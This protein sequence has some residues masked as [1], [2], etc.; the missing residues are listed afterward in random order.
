M[1]S[2]GGLALGKTGLAICRDLRSPYWFGH[3]VDQGT[4]PFLI[5]AQ[6]PAVR[7]SHGEALLR[8]RAIEN[9]MFVS[10]CHR[11]GKTRDE[12]FA[13]G[14]NLIS[15]E[16]VGMLAGRSDQTV[17]TVQVDLDWVIVCRRRL[18]FLRER[19]PD[20]DA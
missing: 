3:V 5:L 14:S 18:P 2:Y 8:A 17:L 13:G 10:G 11:V 7:A 1:R 4:I 6:W 9:Q 15:P 12:S 16:G 20:L 19:R